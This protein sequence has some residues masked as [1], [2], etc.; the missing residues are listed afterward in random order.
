MGTVRKEVP[1]PWTEVKPMDAKV[2]FLSDCLRNKSSFTELCRQH[3]I[4]RKTG[5]K[6]Y[7]RYK[8]QGISGLREQS[9][10]PLY[11][12]ERIPY[13]VR[14]EIILLR[15]KYTWGAKKLSEVL[16]K[17]HPEWTVPSHSTIY[18]ILK[19]DGAIPDRKRKRRVVRTISALRTAQRPNEL[20]T[21]DYKGQF[22]T[23][24]G[25]WCYPLTV[26]DH[27]SRYLLACESVVGT[28]YG[29]ARAVFEK[30]FEHYGIPERIRSDN[31]V[32]FASRSVGGLSR[33][34]LWWIGL[35]IIPERITPGKPQQNGRHERMHRTLKDNT[36]CPPA[37]NAQAQQKRFDA[38]RRMYNEERPHEAI[39][40]QVP[41][42]VYKK[43]ERQLSD[44]PDCIE[45]PIDYKVSLVNHNGCVWID[46]HTVYLGYLLK[47]QKVGIE[48]LS[49]ELWSVCFGPIPLGSI[50]RTEKNTLLFTRESKNCYL[51]P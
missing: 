31:G 37:Q 11:S 38:F 4:S 46:N 15:K 2:L 30:I 28:G 39:G 29:A 49:D 13:R 35:G 42:S 6:W 51:C 36:A 27:Y 3:G 45:Y 7:R 17:Q 5:Y 26:M 32:P 1:M 21:V 34:S 23:R 9:R 47:G 50:K 14:K 24:D 43:S 16:V 20:W 44:V 33:L 10:R 12:P 41:Q 22:R 48:E 18:N 19:A 40:M 8:A 25:L